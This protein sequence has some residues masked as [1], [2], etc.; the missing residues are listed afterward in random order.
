MSLVVIAGFGA[1]GAAP[2]ATMSLL[3]A[4]AAAFLLTRARL[5]ASPDTR[6][7]DLALA[8]SLAAIALQIVPMPGPVVSVLSPHA[9]PLQSMLHVGPTRSSWPLSVDARSTRQALGAAAAPVLLF[10]AARE[11]F[12]R[13]GV[14]LAT[15]V[16]AWS[17]LALVLVTLVQRATAPNLVLWQT[18]PTDAGAQPFGPF[19][20]RNH[21]ATW[22]VMAGAL[23]TGY[24]VAHRRTHQGR[25]TSIRLAVRDW[26]ADG[27]GLML[28]GAVAAMLVGLAASLSRAAIL[29]AGCALVMAL[30]IARRRGAGRGVQAGAALLA[31]L[32]AAAVWANHE[33]I[34]RKFEAATT[35][36]RVVIWRDTMPLVRDFWMAGTGAGTYGRAMLRYQRSAP[37]LHFNQAHSEY[38]QL[39]A[40]GGLLLTVPVVIAVTAWLRLARRQLRRERHEAAWIR[41]GAAAG[42]FGAAVQGIFETG[43]RVPANALLCALLAAMVVH[44]RAAD[45]R[46]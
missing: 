6:L 11:A 46:S 21:F 19:L 13:G 4:S 38:V 24:L 25:H 27:S 39:L 28:A 30:W 29:G 1:I 16:I 31:V 45:R 44:E 37:D 34:E 3:I 9:W 40:E 14:R 8:A 36:E 33:E 18:V 2:A 17:G 23:T 22:L 32:L 12:A 41:I 35:V 5:A 42:L 10:W 20:N 43:W 26:L 15:R 7:L